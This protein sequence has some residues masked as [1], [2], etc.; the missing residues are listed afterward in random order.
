[1][2][3]LTSSI[4]EKLL[5]NGRLPDSAKKDLKP[6]VKFFNPAGAGTWLIT[7]LDVDG[8]TLF[9]LADLGYPEL[10]YVSLSELKSIKVLA[11]L[12]IERDLHFVAKKTLDEYATE[13]RHFER[14]KA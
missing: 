13:A 1:M 12:G 14:I 4:K 11:N 2:N 3:L 10:G 7:E 5:A 9:G 6:V 8:D